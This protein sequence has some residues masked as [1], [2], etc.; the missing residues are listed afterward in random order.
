[1]SA[2]ALIWPAAWGF[3]TSCSI[4]DACRVPALTIQGQS[5]G[6]T[7]VLPNKTV[8]GRTAGVDS[9][10]AARLGE[11]SLEV[12]RADQTF[13]AVYTDALVDALNGRASEILL[14]VTVGG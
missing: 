7:V 9:F 13:R 6:G 2:P 12:V 3:P 5:I 14:P 11:A 1:M 10:Y 8:A 4:S